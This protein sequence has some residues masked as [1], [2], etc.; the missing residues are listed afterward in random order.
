MRPTD[1]FGTFNS[2][3]GGA[4]VDTDA[5]EETAVATLDDVEVTEVD[6][7]IGDD[8]RKE[9]FEEVV[10]QNPCGMNVSSPRQATR[11]RRSK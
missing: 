5:A 1:R 11:A 9:V 2:T 6:G 3:S 8:V 4:E 10:A 7:I